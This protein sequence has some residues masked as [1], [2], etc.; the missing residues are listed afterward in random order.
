M[1]IMDAMEAYHH[2]L[3]NGLQTTVVSKPK[4]P[5]PTAQFKENAKITSKTSVLKF[6]ADP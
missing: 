2:R 3:S 6:S 1:E 5:M 4:M